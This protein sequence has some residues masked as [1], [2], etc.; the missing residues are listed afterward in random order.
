MGPD[1]SIATQLLEIIARLADVQSQLQEIDIQ[2]AR[3]ELLSVE[4]DLQNWSCRLPIH[5]TYEIQRCAGAP[6][7]D[8]ST[9][10]YHKYSHFSIAASWNQY[11]MALCYVNDLLLRYPDPDPTLSRVHRERAE[12]S[13][14]NAFADIR[15]S[16]PFFMGPRSPNQGEPVGA[17]AMEI[18][19]S[20]FICAS[21]TT[22]G[23]EQRQW[24]L[25]QLENIGKGMGLT[26]ALT[27][28]E[29]ARSKNLERSIC[30]IECDEH[31]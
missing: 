5:W 15:A 23:V 25:A 24:A 2:G 14:Q 4:R 10:V 18:M 11:R 16:A 29:L 13:I 12:C 9:S 21:M 26:R 1:Q 22:L 3:R 19:W 20:L 17:G 8:F 30:Q 27:L 6:I 28:A 31:R 7:P